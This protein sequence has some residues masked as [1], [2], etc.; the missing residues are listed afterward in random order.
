MATAPCRCRNGTRRCSL[1]QAAALLYRP[2]QGGSPNA[3]AGTP[4]D[5]PACLPGCLPACLPAATRMICL[6]PWSMSTCRWA[7]PAALWG[8]IRQLGAGS[9]W[10]KGDAGGAAGA[11]VLRHHPPGT[12]CPALSPTCSSPPKCCP[13]LPSTLLT[14]LF[15][16][17]CAAPCSAPCTLPCVPPPPAR[18]WLPRCCPRGKPSTRWSASPAASGRSTHTSS[19]PSTAPTVGG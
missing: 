9:L 18:S 14:L 13:L 1:V 12:F 3:A 15:D 19:S 10:H 17:R 8:L 16:L 6:M 4:A 5:P 7:V 11:A 2:P